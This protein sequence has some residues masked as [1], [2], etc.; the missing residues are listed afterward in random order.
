MSKNRTGNFIAGGNPQVPS[1]TLNNGV[2]DSNEIYT[3]VNNNAWQPA[4]SGTYEIARSLRFR[5]GQT[6]S[7]TKSLTSSSNRKTFTHSCWVKRG[8]FADGY[9]FFAW[10]GGN[11]LSYQVLFE[12]D[13]IRLANN[14]EGVSAV[15]NIKTNAVFRDPS[16]WYHVVVTIDSTQAIE[17]E[18]VKI[19]VNGIRITSFS[20]ATYPSQNFDHSW[21]NSA[22]LQQIGRNTTSGTMDG[23][24]TE[25][26]TIDGQALDASYFGYFDNLGVWQP[27]RY[28][29]SFG[30]NGFYLPFTEN[31]TTTNLG[32]NFAG[33]NYL[34]NSTTPSGFYQATSN[35]TSTTGAYNETVTV[36]QVIT[37]N[38]IASGNSITSVWNNGTFAPPTGTVYTFSALIK[39]LVFPIDFQLYDNGTGAGGGTIYSFTD[40]HTFSQTP[41][42][43]PSYRQSITKLNNGWYRI[44]AAIPYPSSGHYKQIYTIT[45]PTG[46]GT[47]PHYQ[48]YGVQVNLGSNADPL[49]QTNGTAANNDWTLNNISLTAGATY[50]SMVDSPTNAFSTAPDIGGVVSGNYCTG[51]SIWRAG[52]SSGTIGGSAVSWANGNLSFSYSIQGSPNGARCN[53][54][55]TIGNTTGKWYYEFIPG[56]TVN[57]APGITTGTLSGG[58][59]DY[60]DYVNYFQTGVFQTSSGSIPASGASYTTNDVIGVAYDLDNRTVQFFKNGVSQGTVSGFTAGLTWL[61]GTRI[62]TAGSGGSATYNFGQRPFAY[63]PPAGFRSLNTTNL[64]ALGTSAIGRAG[65]R[66]STYFDIVQ[67]TGNGNNP[68]TVSGYKF[69]PDFLWIKRRDA[70]E[71]HQV[72]DSL[73]GTPLTIFTNATNAEVAYTVNIT[74]LTKDG[75]TLGNDS[76]TNIAGG[77]FVAWAWNAGNSTTGGTTVTNTAGSVTSQVKVSSDAGFSI[78]TYT[79]PASG[80]FTFGHGL[81]ATPTFFILK[82]RTAVGNWIAWHPQFGSPTNTGLYF[83][84]NTTFAAGA[85]WLTGVTN[86]TIGIT[87]GQV[88][89]GANPHIVYSFVD[90]PGFSRFGTYTGNGSSDGPFVYTGFRPRWIMS[91]VVGTGDWWIYDSLRDPSNAMNNLLRTNLNGAEVTQ[92]YADFLSNGFK[93]RNTGLND[94][95]VVHIFAAFAESPFALNNRAR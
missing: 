60:V 8:S 28:T 10:A 50:D 40:A 78:A 81:G 35:T 4:A 72:V 85:N 19:F 13:S 55:G 16:A 17:L 2:F 73:R 67:Y 43:L 32:R 34:T 84:G 52:S 33:T 79:P 95:G 45:H 38:T 39:P 80:S 47:T 88:T 12:T 68:R 74:G 42:N 94:S 46:N 30:T 5:G 6:Q 87:Q 36:T 76:N 54:I 57:D 86:T 14:N 58:T 89:S 26:Y 75:F 9:L 92:G 20:Q 24:M 65:L 70:I 71:N 64:Q 51:N 31:Q 7:I 41:S 25:V 3:A 23:Y 1:L 29:G 91:K 48:I 83:N 53:T 56:S 93:I 49:I 62:N 61:P 82:E 77:Q 37:N 18:R 11:A 69:A 59:A 22:V 21:N 27:K 15:W 63:T 44:E 90:V 66:S